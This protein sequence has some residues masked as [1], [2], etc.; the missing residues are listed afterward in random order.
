MTGR[1]F[2][3]GIY[4]GRHENRDETF[5]WDIVPDKL[6]LIVNDNVLEGKLSLE[7]RSA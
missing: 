6:M 5:V 4:E 2:A 7:V 3:R 1:T